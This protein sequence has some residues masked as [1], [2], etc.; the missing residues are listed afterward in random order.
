MMMPPEVTSAMAMTLW[1]G[2]PRRASRISGVENPYRLS[3]ILTGGE[4]HSSRGGGPA[5]LPPPR[6]RPAAAASPPAGAA[7]PRRPSELIASPHIS[8]YISSHV[9]PAAALPAAIC[10]A[11]AFGPAGDTLESDCALVPTAHAARNAP[12]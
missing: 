4:Y 5:C 7:A 1:T 10:E 9:L 12:A 3:N 11:I 6:P 2:S 8:L